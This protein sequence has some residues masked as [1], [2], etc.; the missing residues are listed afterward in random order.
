MKMLQSQT[1]QQKTNTARIGMDQFSSH[2]QSRTRS[3]D[4]TLGF[5]G[6][7]VDFQGKFSKIGSEMFI[8]LCFH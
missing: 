2:L 1:G 3:K 8:F 4:A 6:K 7:P 5:L